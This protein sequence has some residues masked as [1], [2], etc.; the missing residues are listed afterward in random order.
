MKIL[1]TGANGQLGKELHS[2]LESAHPGITV[3]TDVDTL[4]ITDSAEV[5]RF[6]S[7]GE[8]THIVNCA[9]FTAVDAAEKEPA[10]CNKINAEAVRNLASAAYECGA[11]VIHISTDYVFD[12]KAFRP[13]RESDKVNPV[14]TYGTSKRKGEMVLLSMCPEAIIIRTSWLYSP[15]GSNF[16]KTMLRLGVEKS[17]INVVCDQIGTPTYALDLAQAIDSILFSR[18]WIPGIYHFSDEG[19]CSW[20]D[21]TCAIFRIAGVTSCAVNPIPT[22]DYP[23]LA[24]RPFFSVFDKTLI[25]K[26]YGLSI[27]HWEASLS[28]CLSRMTE[29]QD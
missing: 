6:V 16:V 27:P 28:N 7:R 11:K 19:V 20:Y 1:V 13:Y 21:F 26:T 12:G 17:R 4:D 8:F 15:H 23:T 22:E 3:Y 14:S 18:Q 29:C 9:A 10:L 24:Q 25:K 2:V 5:K